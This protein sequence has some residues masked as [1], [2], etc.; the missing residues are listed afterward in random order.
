M[1]NYLKLNVEELT[2]STLTLNIFALD[3]SGSMEGQKERM[4]RESLEVIKTNMLKLEDTSSTKIAVIT[5]GDYVKV[6][7][8][9]AIENFNTNYR[10]RNERTALYDAICEAENQ[11]KY[12]Y[13]NYRSKCRLNI[14]VIFLS[15]GKDYRSYKSRTSAL[16]SVRRMKQE[17]KVA[18]IFY[19]IEEPGSMDRLTTFA[20]ELGFDVKRVENSERAMQEFSRQVSTMLTTSSRTGQTAKLNSGFD[21]TLSQVAAKEF[22]ESLEQAETKIVD[23]FAD[24]FNEEDE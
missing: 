20:R 14:N 13:E 6:G 1:S 24:I 22:G 12:L 7:D 3:I 10:S 16:E 21:A 11:V 2:S 17:Y 8:F 4:L 15:D 18:T 23:P 5:F 19:A 9:Q